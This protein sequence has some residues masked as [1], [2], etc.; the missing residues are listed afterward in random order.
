MLC[1]ARNCKHFGKWRLRAERNSRSRLDYSD[2]QTASR[3]DSSK[4]IYYG[5]NGIKM[6]I[7]HLNN[8]KRK[9]KKCPYLF[10]YLFTF[11]IVNKHNNKQKNI[12]AKIADRNSRCSNARIKNCKKIL[13]NRKAF[14]RVK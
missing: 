10:K 11:I 4:N 3:L 2:W 8:F 9:C 14:Q 1:A 5:V 12:L 7:T 13:K 6:R